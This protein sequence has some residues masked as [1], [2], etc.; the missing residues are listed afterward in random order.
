MDETAQRI[1]EVPVPNA[2]QV[3]VRTLPVAA[4]VIIGLPLVIRLV[5]DEN[6]D[7]RTPWW[8]VPLLALFGLAFLTDRYAQ[9]PRPRIDQRVGD[10]RWKPA[11]A[12][13][14]KTGSLPEHPEVRTAVGVVA[15]ETLE[16]LVFG[17]AML[18]AIV[19]SALAAPGFPWLSAL[20]FPVIFTGIKAVRAR[21]A[22]V[23]LR[24]LHTAEPAAD[25]LN[26]EAP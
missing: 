18:V 10:A 25:D 11:F 19:L 23:Y 17:V 20:S 5:L 3:L 26:Q 12:A 1:D 7:T 16:G 22:W 4:V 2:G 14:A 6:G 9:A 21:R 8:P 13:A 15:C 24:S